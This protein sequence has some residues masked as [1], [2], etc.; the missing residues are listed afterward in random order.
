MFAR[1]IA[2]CCC[3][4]AKDTY[5]KFD[6]PQVKFFLPKP[7][8]TDHDGAAYAYVLTAFAQFYMLVNAWKACV[9]YT[10][11]FVMNQAIDDFLRLL[12]MICILCMVPG[13]KL[14]FAFLVH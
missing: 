9:N 4:G 8:E 7:A 2:V 10:T 12:F 5:S 11:H 6:G 3:T 14:L 1:D 13:A